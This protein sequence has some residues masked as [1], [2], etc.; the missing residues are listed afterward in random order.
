M[1]TAIWIRV[2]VL[3]V[4]ASII[5]T[6][7]R[8]LSIALIQPWGADGRLGISPTAYGLLNSGQIALTGIIA[9]GIGAFTA[10][11]HERGGW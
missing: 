4:I 2:L 3:W 10:W 6:L 11:R 7:L 8:T 1:R 9:F 5:T